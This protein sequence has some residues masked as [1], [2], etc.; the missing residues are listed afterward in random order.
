MVFAF[1]RCSHHQIIHRVHLHLQ[2]HTELDD[3]AHSSCPDSANQVLTSG[4]KCWLCQDKP[5]NTHTMWRMRHRCV[6]HKTKNQRGNGAGALCGTCRINPL[7]FAPCSFSFSAASRLAE[8][9]VGWNSLERSGIPWTWTC[10]PP[11]ADPRMVMQSCR[12][13]RMHGKPPDTTAAHAGPPHI[14]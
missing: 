9:A 14:L 8:H 3:T 6:G 1:K 13:I 12:A 10:S 11:R 7:S 2:V 5:T 4:S